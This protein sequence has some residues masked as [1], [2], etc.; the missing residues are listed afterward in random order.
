M[1]EETKPTETKKESKKKEQTFYAKG[2]RYGWRK[3]LKDA[4][5]KPVAKI[6]A[7]GAPLY[8]AG[9]QVFQYV[10]M[11]FWPAP[12][13]KRG[14][15]IIR[16]CYYTTDDPEEITILNETA[17]RSKD[18]LSEAEFQSMIAPEMYKY[19]NM[20]EALEVEKSELKSALEA[21]QKHIAELTS[22]GQNPNQ[23]RR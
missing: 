8:Q 16:N 23:G 1:S 9:R 13:I 18:V 7:S 14:D 4:N 3:P 12:A 11:D 19:K 15:E 5:G 17:K 21:A 10:E 2:E 6:N 20:A 22:S